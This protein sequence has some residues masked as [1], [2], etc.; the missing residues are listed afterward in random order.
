MSEQ[1]RK[2]GRCEYGIRRKE[3]DYEGFAGYYCCFFHDIVHDYY[4]ECE[5]FKKKE[6]M[7]E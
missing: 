3:Y 2:C 7:N 4:V 5:Y 6:R 1:K